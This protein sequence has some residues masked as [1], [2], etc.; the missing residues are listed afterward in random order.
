MNFVREFINR[1]GIS[2]LSTTETTNGCRVYDPLTRRRFFIYK[3]EG[4]PLFFKI[5]IE[6]KNMWLSVPEIIDFISFGEIPNEWD[7]EMR[8]LEMKQQ[9]NQ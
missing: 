3:F 2:D 8:E 9:C 4:C 1:V 6:K 7:R 5:R